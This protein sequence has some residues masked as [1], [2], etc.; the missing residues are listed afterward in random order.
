MYIIV[1][2]FF[3]HIEPN[4]WNRYNYT[5]TPADHAADFP[6]LKDLIHAVKPAGK[7]IVG[8]DVSGKTLNYLIM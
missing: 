5:I 2:L 7:R 3:V 6:V 1:V 4:A 8:P